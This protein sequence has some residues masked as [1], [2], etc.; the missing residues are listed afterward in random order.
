MTYQQAQNL[1]NFFSSLFIL[2]FSVLIIIATDSIYYPTSNSHSYFLLSMSLLSLGSIIFTV[3]NI[4]LR[5][6]TKEWDFSLL[7]NILSS[8]GFVL[9][10]YIVL[11]NAALLR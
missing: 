4:I 10:F 8:I 11:S 7:P 9:I 5:W 3:V 1:S 6:K 2:C